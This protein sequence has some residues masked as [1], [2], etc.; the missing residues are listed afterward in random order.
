MIPRCCMR[1]LSN[2]QRSSFPA[3]R[4]RNWNIVND[5]AS[6]DGIQAPDDSGFGAN[7]VECNTRSTN[8]LNT[9]SWKNIGGNVVPRYPNAWLRLMRN[10]NVLQAYSSSNR[11]DPVLLAQYDTGTNAAGPLPSVVY[12]GICTVAHDNDRITDPVP[13]PPY[14]YYNTAEYA[15]DTSSFVVPA[16]LSASKSGNNLIISWTPTG[17]HL[18]SSPAISGARV[19]WQ[20]IGSANPATV[21]LGA[22]SQFFRVVNP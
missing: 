6:A 2:I 14:K 10:G 8:S 20:N 7:N 19:N 16:V 12:L 22:G 13:P 21:P 15:D 17:G 1:P 11:V 9:V 3:A 5:P 18:E 4:S